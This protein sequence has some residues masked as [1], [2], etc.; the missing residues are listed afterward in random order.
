MESRTESSKFTLDLSG[1]PV[2]YLAN[3]YMAFLE[4]LFCNR[5][6]TSKY[7]IEQKINSRIKSAK[8]LNIV[9]LRP[10]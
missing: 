10:K 1:I 9:N 8:Y 3:S 7:G 4:R 5:K 2:V 6:R